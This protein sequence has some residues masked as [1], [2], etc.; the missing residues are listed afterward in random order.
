[1]PE[2]E[3]PKGTSYF[4][5]GVLIVVTLAV[6]GGLGGALST[7]A[8][9]NVSQSQLRLWVG[10]SVG[11]YLLVVLFG[12]FQFTAGN[13]KWGLHLVLAATGIA[14]LVGIGVRC[15]TP[16]VPVSLA[17]ILGL[18][19][20]VGWQ[21]CGRIEPHWLRQLTRASVAAAI[22]GPFLTVE[23][24]LLQSRE[25]ELHELFMTKAGVI[26][27]YM[28]QHWTGF[29]LAAAVMWCISEIADRRRERTAGTKWD[30]G[31]IAAA[32]LLSLYGINW[33]VAGAWNPWYGAAEGR[34]WW[35][36]VYP[37]RFHYRDLDAQTARSAYGWLG[38]ALFIA[39]AKGDSN[40]VA[41]LIRS[42]ADVEVG[43]IATGWK[44]L[45]YAGTVDIAKLLIENGA[46]VNST[47]R[48]GWTALHNVAL[49]SKQHDIAQ[50]LIDAGADV[51][52][53]AAKG[54]TPL[55]YAEEE[56]TRVLLAAG[57]DA[58]HTDHRGMTPLHRATYQSTARQLLAA[59][60]EL[61]AVSKDG[62]TPLCCVSRPAT[63]LTLVE[64]GADVNYRDP[65]GKPVL[66]C[67]RHEYAL[68]TIE[69]L[70]DAGADLNAV[71]VE[72]GRKQTFLSVVD[73]RLRQDL[74][75]RGAKT[76]AELE[77]SGD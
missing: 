31:R 66:S 28:A 57:A 48:N 26:I 49:S 25:W 9:D 64:A 56:M 62:R 65:T 51:N 46:D 53:E 43:E 50:V 39:A 63:A 73:G 36:V 41:M 59:G 75:R 18:L 6:A 38:S 23:V 22:A 21:L 33:Y 16:I 54:E 60:A 72:D 20:Y 4:A 34:G 71:W 52:A 67:F 47:D 15:G 1:M 35:K 69:V 61:E 55:F 7:L 30:I 27:A 17:A 8:E 5:T 3:Q 14:M 11:G 12:L 42:G 70:V 37:L 76:P 77:S 45:Y 68:D 58:K 74:R 44:P 13:R 40:T 2:N 24:W 19:Y 10:G 29:L 32:A